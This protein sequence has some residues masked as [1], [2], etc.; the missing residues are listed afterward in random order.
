[1]S[2]IVDPTQYEHQHQAYQPQHQHEAYQPQYEQAHQQECES[3]EEQRMKFEAG[4]HWF[5]GGL[6]SCR[7]YLTSVK[8]WHAGYVSIPNFKS[9]IPC[10]AQEET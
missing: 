9:R 5:L 10:L 6:M 1:M 2:Q 3:E 8:M 4:P 7:F